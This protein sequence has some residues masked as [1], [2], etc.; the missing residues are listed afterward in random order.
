M[1]DADF[2]HL[3]SEKW[4]AHWSKF[5]KSFYARR[6]IPHPR[7]RGQTSIS[8]HRAVL[9]ARPGTLI[10]HANHDTLDNQR[11]NLNLSDKTKNA[12]NRKGANAG[13]K[14][15]VRGVSWHRKCGK[16]AV[17]IVVAGKRKYIGVFDTVESAA[18][19]YAASGGSR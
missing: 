1:D 10:D 7:G 14:S 13:T 17:E 12:L 4:Y 3:N 6:N 11:A 2:S 9:G 15:G 5:T 18:R 8:M 19:A 16:W